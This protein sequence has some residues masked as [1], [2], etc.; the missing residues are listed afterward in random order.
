M[1]PRNVIV[2]DTN[3][4]ITLIVPASKSTRL[5][6]RLEAAGW[7]VAAS[8]QLLAEV[9]DKLRTKATLR[10]WVNLSDHDIE[11]F[12]TGMLIEL[13]SLVPGICQTV[14]A[15][16]A[17]PND[18]IIIAAAVE[19]NASY[20]VTEDRHLLDMESYE[21]IQ[22]MNRAQFAAELDRLGIPQLG[23]S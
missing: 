20:I 10:R 16:P 2:F 3:V 12:L 7:E 21:G 14:G 13:V 8:P 1:S 9:A 22:I 23:P 5:F 18:D 4:L 15:V 11:E 17:D 6:Q 19:A